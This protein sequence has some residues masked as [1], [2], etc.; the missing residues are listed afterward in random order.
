[1]MGSIVVSGGTRVS[2]VIFLD[3][4]AEAVVHGFTSDNQ[5]LLPFRNLAHHL[6]VI[7]PVILFLCLILPTNS[8]L[9]FPTEPP[10]VYEAVDDPKFPILDGDDR[11][12][13]GNA[14]WDGVIA[15]A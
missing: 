6:E 5:F 7:A 4:I 12:W 10:R 14:A 15:C 11:L 2:S 13:C 9:E 8:Q 3:H 1:M